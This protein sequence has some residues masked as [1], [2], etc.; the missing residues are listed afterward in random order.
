M[1]TNDGIQHKQ[2]WLIYGLHPNKKAIPPIIITI[3]GII[4][5]NNFKVVRNLPINLRIQGIPELSIPLMTSL[6]PSKY[7]VKK[8]TI[9]HT[10]SSLGG[11][12][13]YPNLELDHSRSFPAASSGIAT[14]SPHI[15]EHT[16]DITTPTPATSAPN[17]STSASP[18][19]SR[20]C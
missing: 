12:V 10:L 17:P 4:S 6:Y 5:N 18:V 13:S 1:P 7:L 3:R 8:N 19:E 11:Q 9:V 16:R 20:N 2:N 15:A 14:R